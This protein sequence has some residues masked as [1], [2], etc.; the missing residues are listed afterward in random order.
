[1]RA[2]ACVCR[3]HLARRLV[4]LLYAEPQLAHITHWSLRAAVVDFALL[5]EGG[6]AG[7]WIALALDM[8]GS[9]MSC[10]NCRRWLP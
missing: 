4:Q 7:A 10:R 3:S 5:Q 6:Q 8:L 9:R 1:M 2:P